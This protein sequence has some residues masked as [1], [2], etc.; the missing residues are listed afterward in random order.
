MPD[1]DG[2]RV[3][4]C[5]L[6]AGD[7]DLASVRPG[8]L[9]LRTLGESD[10]D[11]EHLL[12]VSGEQRQRFVANLEGFGDWAAPTR[13][14]DWSARATWRPLALGSHDGVI[15]AQVITDLHRAWDGPPTLLELTGPAGGRWTVG[16]GTPTATIRADTVDFLRARSG[17]NDHPALQAGGD[18]A[19]AAAAAAARIAF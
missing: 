8:K 1:Q 3:Q 4:R 5:L 10:L 17:R 11:P 13:C 16:H 9:L 14:A 19:A 12:E 6:D 2:Q 15:V 7:Q 18:P